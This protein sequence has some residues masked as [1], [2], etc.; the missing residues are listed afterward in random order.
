M[1]Y[2]MIKVVELI[3][4]KYNHIALPQMSSTMNYTQAQPP[5]FGSANNDKALLHKKNGILG[6]FP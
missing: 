2:L 4:L 3:R 1:K 5:K 6:N